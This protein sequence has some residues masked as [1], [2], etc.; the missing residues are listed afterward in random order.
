MGV[1]IRVFSR[2]RVAVAL[3]AGGGALALTAPAYAAVPLTAVIVDSFS[4]TNSQH[5]TA[6]EPDTYSFG[7]TIVVASQSGRFTDGGSSDIAFA[8]STNGGTSFT[9]GALPG[10]THNGPGGGAF[11]RASDP[12]VAYDASHNV[13]LISSIGI[14]QVGSSIE[15]P[16]VLASRS[17]DG[18]LSW[19]SPV[20]V[21]TSAAKD[22]DKNWTVCDNHPASPFYGHCYT[23]FDDHSLGDRI[24]MSTSTDGGL[25]W[26]PALATANTA[27]GLGGQPVVQPNGTVIVPAANASESAIISFRSTNG[28][29]SWSSTTTVAPVADHTVAG[30]LRSGPLPSAEI[31]AAGKVFVVWQDCRFRAGCTRNDIVLSSSADGVTWSAVQRIPIDATGSTVDHFIPGIAVDPATSGSTAKLALTYYFYDKYNCGRKCQLRVGYVQS[32]NGG[33]TWT[34]PLTLAGPFSVSLVASTTQ[35]RMVGDYIS[36]SWVGGKAFGAFAVG[37]TPTGGAAFDEAIYVPGGGLRPAGG[38]NGVD[39]TQVA[40]TGSSDHGPRSRPVR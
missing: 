19:G 29:A 8:T 25:T 28:G 35:G 13:W 11:D 12:S 26:G 15:V 24:L 4:N 27:T 23:E 6:V 7:N 20:T 36:T 34:T 9:S 38:T 22:L 18:G 1:M 10:L 16:A 21:A 32:T 37:K 39:P 33:A 5:A 3:L 14:N 17:T 30:G 31:D 40:V 2:R